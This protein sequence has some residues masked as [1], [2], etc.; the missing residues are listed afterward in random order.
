MS[1]FAQRGRS[2]LFDRGKEP[3]EVG[4]KHGEVEQ[5]PQLGAGRATR[6]CSAGFRYFGTKLFLKGGDVLVELE[7]FSGEKEL[8]S[9]T[10]GAP[11]SRVVLGPTGLCCRH[12]R[13][14]VD[15]PTISSYQPG[16]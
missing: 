10:L 11:H 8:R 15:L 5:T 4:K 12:L 14:V 6:F 3:P 13:G 2:V 16:W 7:K 9:K 1:G